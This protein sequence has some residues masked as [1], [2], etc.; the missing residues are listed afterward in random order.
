[1]KT[2]IISYLKQTVSRYPHKP[3]VTDSLGVVSFLELDELSDKIAV[4]IYTK[5]TALR[6]PVAVFLPKNS[7]A[8][9]SFIG[10]FRKFFFIIFFTIFSKNIN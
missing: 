1:M 4:A 8:I 7:W 6:T 10:I 3:A 5:V 2:N 9:L